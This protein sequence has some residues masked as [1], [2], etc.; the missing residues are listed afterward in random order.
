LRGDDLLFPPRESFLEETPPGLLFDKKR[1]PSCERGVI[2]YCKKSVPFAG[3]YLPARREDLPLLEERDILTAARAVPPRTDTPP[4]RATAT[5]HTRCA[6]G[7]ALF[8]LSSSDQ[9]SIP[10]VVR[11]TTARRAYRAAGGGLRS[12][13]G[14]LYIFFFFFFIIFFWAAARAPVLPHER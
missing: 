3:R 12:H 11:T 4:R 6:E 7:G 13:P 5:N 2:F 8:F 14:L 9:A 1:A 10:R